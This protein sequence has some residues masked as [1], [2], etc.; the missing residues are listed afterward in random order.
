MAYVVVA[1]WTCRE[2][3]EAAVARAVEALVQPS[4]AEPGN[5]LYQPHRDP[6]DPTA[7]QPGERA[8]AGVPGGPP[9]PRRVLL[10]PGAVAVALQRRG[11]AAEHLAGAGHRE[12]PHALGAQVDADPDVPVRAHA[13]A[14]R[15]AAR[16]GPAIS[17][18]Y[19]SP[20]RIS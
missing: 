16:R 2:G 14:R 17:P 1:R 8:G 12:R 5:L 10:V 9:P 15:D 18:S 6:A 19:Q 4:R 11:A 13:G 7:G 20:G 3:E